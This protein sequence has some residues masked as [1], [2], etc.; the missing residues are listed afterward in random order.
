MNNKTLPIK[1]LRKGKVR[2]VYD[3][4]D[5]LLIVSSDR[6]SAFDFVLDKPI[7]D[8]GK[9]LTQISVF[10]LDKTK[11][12]V[13]N[14]LITT[15]MAQIKSALP[16]GVELDEYYDGRSM[17]VHKAERIDFECVVR[18]Y[19]AGSGWKDYQNTG[20]VCGHKL[21][22]G[23]AQAQKLETPIFTPATKV[24]TGHDE[25]VS[26]EYM[27]KELGEK[28]AGELRDISLK[29]YTFARDYLEP[30]GIILADTKFEFGLLGD[31]I[32]LIDEVF[33]PDS[34]R[35]WE[36]REYKVGTS[37][38][39]FDKQIVRD[40]LLSTD[41]DRKSPPPDLPDEVIAKT[42]GRYKQALDQILS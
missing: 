2:E 42:S 33:T 5:K 18:G 8:K 35:F 19:L 30:R 36:S 7:T 15:N 31:K 39:S 17:L 24:D 34:S 9:V 4:E 38:V 21:P 37:P 11:H 14:H 29:L 28:L 23:L 20:L 26:F 3:L 1:L 41:W 6:V 10:W 13:D 27:A 16:Q 12:I 40:Y 22:E 32:I 25:N